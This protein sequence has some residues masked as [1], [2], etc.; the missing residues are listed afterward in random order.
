MEKEV[1]G[2]TSVK[3]DDEKIMKE[4]ETKLGALE[5]KELEERSKKVRAEE[6]MRDR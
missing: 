5:V 6:E 1:T 2:L 3:E 4:L